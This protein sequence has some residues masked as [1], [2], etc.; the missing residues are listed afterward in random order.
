MAEFNS[1]V[2]D[3]I[4][5]RFCEKAPEIAKFANTGYSF[6]EWLNWEAY[7]ACVAKPGWSV[8]PRPAYAKLS[9]EPCRD[10]GDLLISEHEPS[11]Q[12]LVE[13][14]LVHDWTNGNKWREKIDWDTKKLARQSRIV[15]RAMGSEL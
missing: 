11:R 5:Q 13:I 1:A 8:A 2:F 12:T 4:V 3:T 10:F 9:Q 7:A 6:E 14:A 15:L